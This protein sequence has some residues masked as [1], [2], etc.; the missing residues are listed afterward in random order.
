MTCRIV[1]S[2]LVL[3]LFGSIDA[4]SILP[5]YRNASAPIEQ[6]IEDLLSRMTPHEKICQLNQ[7][8]LGLNDNVNNVEEEAKSI[9]AELGSVIYFDEN[10]SLRNEL[11]RRAVEESRLGI[12]MLFGNDIIHGFRTIYPIPLAQACSWKCA[13]IYLMRCCGSP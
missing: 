4:R 9:P 1:S 7:F 12:P 5:L 6:R 2:V 13:T 3:A 8:T 11:Q 10:P